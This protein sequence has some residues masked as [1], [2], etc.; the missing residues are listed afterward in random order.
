M[1]TDPLCTT[2]EDVLNWKV[3]HFVCISSRLLFNHLHNVEKLRGPCGY[4]ITWE[5]LGG[6]FPVQ[7]TVPPHF[8]KRLRELK[9]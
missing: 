3:V 1:L 5:S 4:V 7:S 6:L 8:T 9:I 2:W